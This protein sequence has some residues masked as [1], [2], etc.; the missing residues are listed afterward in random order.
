MISH[1]YRFLPLLSACL[2]AGCAIEPSPLT[3]TELSFVG[4]ARVDAVTANQEPVSGPIDLHQAMA[5]GLLYNLDHRVEIMQ[6]A[7]RASELS[8]AHYQLLPGLVANSGYANRNN[9]LASSSLNLVTGVPNFGSSTSQE[10]NL[11]TAD[12]TFSWHVLDFGLSYIRARQAADKSLIAEEMRRKAAHRIVEDIRTAYWRAISAERLIRRLERL[13]ARAADA[14]RN[15]RN[16][17][18]EKETSPITGLTHVRELVEIERTLKELARELATARLQLAALMNLK[19]GTKFSL[20]Q[21]AHFTVPALGRSTS[22]MIAVAIEKRPELRE[23]IYQKRINEQELH[24]AYLEL[25][26]GI[27]LHAG[28]N[29]DSNSFLLH[30]NWLGWGA[31]ASWNL[32]KA[33]Q[34]P[35]KRDLVDAQDNVLEARGL[36]LTMAIMTQVHVSHVRLR[37][38]TDELKTAEEYRSVQ[39]TL[40][41]KIAIETEAGRVSEQ[42]L[43]REELGAL[44][45]EAKRDI[46]YAAVQN[47][48]ANCLASMGLDP[49]GAAQGPGVSV[50][51]LAARLRDGSR[52]NGQ[53]KLTMVRQG[54]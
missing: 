47:A 39:G 4:N 29:A 8:L 35:A 21:P 25:L 52:A 17:A 33:F 51:D 26:P 19:P 23:N 46:A 22:E 12:L 1:R 40:A 24:A 54:G 53:P 34:V 13:K 18:S 7:V 15:A 44:V 16:L 5:R 42:T 3:D 41:A 32:I 50:S 36:A 11:R 37:H 9:D 30:N 2:I 43:I 14:K 28:N 10:R 20:V 38:L 48:Y 45:A 6:T 31:R 27:Q 49:I